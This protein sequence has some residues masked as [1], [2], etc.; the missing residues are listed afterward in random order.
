MK[1]QL[2][3]V[4]VFLLIVFSCHESAHVKKITL[5]ELSIHFKD[6]APAG[7]VGNGKSLVRT[8]PSGFLFKKGAKGTGTFEFM[9]GDKIIN[10]P[11]SLWNAEFF[12]GGVEYSCIDKGYDIKILNGASEQNKYLVCFLHEPD[13]HVETI[14]DGDIAISKRQSEIGNKILTLFSTDEITFPDTYQ[15][16]KRYLQEP[17][18]GKLWLK[19]PSGI[20]DQ[21]VVF[22]QYLLDLGYD[23][24]LMLCELFRWQDIW[25]RDLGSGLLPGALA[26]GR[27]TM[28]RKAL[29]Y[30]LNRYAEMQPE[31]CK[32]SNDPSQGGTASGIGWTAL[33]VWNY[34]LYSGDKEYLEK[35]VEI[36]RPWVRHWEKRDY[37]QDGLIIDVTEF[38]DH[39]IMM[40]TTNGVTT[41]AANSMYAGLFKNFANIEAALGNTDESARLNLLYERTRNAINTVF[42]NKEKQYFNNMELWGRIDERSSQA[43][44]SMLLKVGA[45]DYNRAKQTLRHVKNNNWN[46]HGSITIIPGMHHVGMDN[47]QNV[48]IWP[49]WNLWES[50]ARFKYGDIQGGLKL[51]ELASKTIKDEKYPGL[52]EENQDIDGRSY[53]GNALV[54]AGGN[55]LDVVVKNLLGI[56]ILDAGWKKIKIAPGIPSEW[57]EFEAQ[58]PTLSGVLHLSYKAGKL[59]VT[60]TDRNIR[61]IYVP[62]NV[63]VKGA[64]SSLIT[65]TKRDDIAY[66][67]PVAKKVPELV[68]EDAILFHDPEFHQHTPLLPLKQIGVSGLSNINAT[69]HKTIIVQG[70]ALP[71]Y[72]KNGKSMQDVFSEFIEKG[73]NIVFYGATVNPKSKIDGRGLLGEQCGIIDWY[74]YL[75]EREKQNIANWVFRAAPN[76][77]YGIKHNWHLQNI[78]L[79]G[80]TKIDRV[81]DWKKAPGLKT[82]TG[83]YGGEIFLNEN[84]KEK[85][86]I[87]ELGQLLASDNVYINGV[88]VGNYKDMNKLMKQQ[89]PTNTKYPHSNNFKQ[90]SRVYFIKPENKAYKAF[91]FGEKNT[92]TIEIFNDS[93]EEGFTEKNMPNIGTYTTTKSWQPIDEDIPG[94]GLCLPKRKGVNYWGNEQFFN[95]WSTKNGLFGFEVKGKGIEFSKEGLLQEIPAADIPVNSAYTDFAVFSPWYFQPL[96]YTQTGQDLLYPSQK[97]R[98]PCIARIVNTETGGSFILIP[99]S[100]S[101]ANI[102]KKVLM[103]LND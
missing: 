37:N 51:L 58:V 80:W 13:I 41:L 19:S 32:N 103:L 93:W 49:W 82:S 54:T 2:F 78:E 35:A 30:D 6:K 26:S 8:T 17:Y 20:I 4:I 46:E 66:S 96:A 102:G 64:K 86:I 89:Y 76:H 18:S 83:W 97:E 16:I 56:E 7:L 99:P 45:T 50:E 57:Q 70:N 11:D 84:L 88:L 55:L 44:Q 31:D 40:L 69:S 24:N 95:S 68:I 72:D 81:Q 22:S 34:Y 101:N 48:K 100:I 61:H 3:L 1:T 23:G 47:D 87:I 60:S 42:W 29:D 91:K 12:P 62:E 38:M 14:V 9:H 36:L 27:E 77:E 74:Q 21:A 98:Y 94:I 59:T 52:I 65:A 73:G 43:S 85:E 75:P 15:E 39:M 92:I 53:G 28:A 79:Q 90:V 25:A 5:D 67:K 33:S 71:L 63:V 10:L